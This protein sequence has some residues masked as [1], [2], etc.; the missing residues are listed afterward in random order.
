MPNPDHVPNTSGQKLAE[1]NVARD[2]KPDIHFR[3]VREYAEKA[4][5]SAG[6]TD[7][8]L[9]L[10]AS[11][12]WHADAIG[13]ALSQLVEQA[14]DGR[15][16]NLPGGTVDKVLDR[17]ESILTSLDV[18]AKALAEAVTDV[19]AIVGNPGRLVTGA[20]DRKPLNPTRAPVLPTDP[21]RPR[22]DKPDRPGPRKVD[23]RPAVVPPPPKPTPTP[24][25]GPVE[26]SKPAPTPTK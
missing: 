24:A 2:A 17:A 9:R 19:K 26:P 1:R 15:L 4:A 11:S 10:K 16:A 25:P 12:G 6:L 18:Q 20:D 14:K 13:T 5:D 3:G 7:P 21:N 23:P 8:D 22:A